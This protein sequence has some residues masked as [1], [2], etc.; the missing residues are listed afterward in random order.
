M[1]KK[2]E[3]DTTVFATVGECAKY[4]NLS[5]GMVFKLIAEGKMPARRFGRA[6]RVPWSWLRS[7]AGDLAA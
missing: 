2:D 4:L 6:V 3:P 5:K 7:Q 1:Y